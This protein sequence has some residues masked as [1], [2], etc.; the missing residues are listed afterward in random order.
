MHPIKSVS[1]VLV[2]APIEAHEFEPSF[3]C[4]TVCTTFACRDRVETLR[5]E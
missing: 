2:A 3:P 5:N 4:C 1:G